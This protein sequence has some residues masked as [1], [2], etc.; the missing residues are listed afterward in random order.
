MTAMTDQDNATLDR[1]IGERRTHRAFTQ[2]YP[3]NDMIEHI[4]HAGLHAPFAASAIRS[5]GDYFRQF[6]VVRKDSQAMGKL[7]PLVFAKAMAMAKDLEL[8]SAKDEQ[9]HCRAAAFRNRLDA[10]KKMGMVPGVGTAPFYVVVAEM[11]GFPPVE[12]Q[13]L[14]HCMENM[15]LKATALGLGFQLVSITAQL[16]DNPGFCR[17]LGLEPEKQALMG[18][19]IGYPAEKLSPSIRP[20]VNEV[21]RWLD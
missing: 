9:V 10:I 16:A 17:I 6:F 18:C 15:W 13:S 14:A 19:A 3:P 1:I 20:G 21:T 12:Q 5:D 11:K 7:V 4:I 8:A 2:G